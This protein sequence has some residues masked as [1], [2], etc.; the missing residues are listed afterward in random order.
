MKKFSSIQNNI[1]STRKNLNYNFRGYS[2]LNEDSQEGQNNNQDNIMN[3]NQNDNQNNNQNDNQNNNQ[4]DNQ[5]NNSSVN[6]IQFF[7]KLF[8]SRE[9]THIYHLQEESYKNHVIL[10]E[11]YDSILDMIDELIETYQGQYQMVEGYD[12]IDTS[13]TKTKNVNQYFEELASFVTN[14]RSIF[15]DKDTHI[16]SIIDSI[17]ILIYRTLYK[18][19]ILSKN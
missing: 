1:K 2:R 4:N 6:I 19:K 10:N 11:Y 8:E 5:N 16:Q 17:L 3:N 15:S 18:L 9:M 12:I 7:S 13:E 14:N